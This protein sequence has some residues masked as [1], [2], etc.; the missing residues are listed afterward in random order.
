MKPRKGKR[1]IPKNW[2]NLQGRGENKGILSGREKALAE[3]ERRTGD[4]FKERHRERAGR[5]PT[6]Y[7]PKAEALLP[8]R[9]QLIRTKLREAGIP[10]EAVRREGKKPFIVKQG[11]RITSSRGKKW[12]ENNSYTA[13]EKI[14]EIVAKMHSLGILHH[15][16]KMESFSVKDDELVLLDL[17]HA[18]KLRI[19]RKKVSGFEKPFRNE[20]R[21]FAESFAD[22]Y[23]PARRKEGYEETRQEVISSLITEI[24]HSYEGKLFDLVDFYE[25]FPHDLYK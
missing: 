22:I 15:N 8:K 3:T 24:V 7:D 18:K 21:D 5:L 9:F 17:M 1:K 20:L 2:G 6:I 4:H 11:E 13:R 16:L 10:I 14:I 23:I 12:F 19:P 25:V